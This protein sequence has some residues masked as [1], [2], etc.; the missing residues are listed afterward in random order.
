[1]SIPSKGHGDS[2]HNIP[3][4]APKRSS[5]PLSGIG[6]APPPFQEADA[7]APLPMRKPSVW[8]KLMRLISGKAAPD[9][10]HL[11]VLGPPAVVPGQTVTVMVNLHTP[12]VTD[13]V[14]TLSRAIQSDAELLGTGCVGA[15]VV[16]DTELAVHLTVTSAGVSKSL[17]TFIWRGSPRRLLFELHVPWEASS[18]P[19]LGVVTVGYK[20]ICVAKTEISLNILPR[21]G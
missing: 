11:S 18:G 9:V 14:R 15:M 12:E 8:R 4:A 16:R 2:G 21:K 13:S 1:S 20:N 17:L 3:K 10:I 19:A 7:I 6:L 5:N